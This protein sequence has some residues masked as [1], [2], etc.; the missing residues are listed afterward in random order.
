M[1]AGLLWTQ[2]GTSA[3][4]ALALGDADAD[5][6]ARAY[7]GRDVTLTGHARLSALVA[8]LAKQRSH[9]THSQDRLLQALLAR[10]PNQ[11]LPPAVDDDTLRQVAEDDPVHGLPHYALQRWAWWARA[12]HGELHHRFVP[13]RLAADG[14]PLDSAPC[15]G[16]QQLLHVNRHLPLK[17]LLLRGA[18]GTGKSTLL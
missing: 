15:T 2:D 7:V 18:P 6:D 8:H 1:P 10:D 14:A 5:A 17:A 9:F 16:L 11:L 3:G 4:G 12:S 13:L